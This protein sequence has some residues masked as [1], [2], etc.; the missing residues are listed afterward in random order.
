MTAERRAAIELR[1]VAGGTP[2]LAGYAAKFDSRSGDLGGFTEII[3]PGAFTRSLASNSS[4]P[5]ALVHHR[6]ELVLGRRSAGTLRLSEDAAGLAFEIDLPSTQ[7]GRDILVSVQRGDIR[8]ASFAFNVPK[9]GDRWEAR[10]GAMTREL[11]DVDLHEISL[12][13][14]PVYDTTTACA[15]A[16]SESAINALRRSI[17]KRRVAV[18]RRWMETL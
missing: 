1:A 8:G 5:L 13:S 15:R 17:P 14:R 6:P 11:I 4:D 12:T 2:R 7:T 9:G 3:R 18:A 10:D 16:V